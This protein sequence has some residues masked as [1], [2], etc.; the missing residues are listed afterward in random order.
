VGLVLI[1]ATVV[2]GVTE[3]LESPEFIATIITGAVLSIT[4]PFVIVVNNASASDAMAKA[5][6]EAQ[7]FNRVRA[8]AEAYKKSRPGNTL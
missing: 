1:V 6:E 2:L 4:G 5:K 8:A 7:E 3:L